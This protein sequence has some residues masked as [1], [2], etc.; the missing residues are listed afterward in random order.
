MP[1]FL[2][3]PSPV[4]NPRILDTS[5]GSPYLDH[6]TTDLG[7]FSAPLLVYWYLGPFLP[8]LTSS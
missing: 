2:P 7:V 5:L 4:T 6:H 1:L 3:T 8:W